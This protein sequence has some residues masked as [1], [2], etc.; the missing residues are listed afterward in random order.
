MV[1]FRKLFDVTLGPADVPQVPATRMLAERGV[2]GVWV[3][4]PGVDTSDM[5]PTLIYLH[6]GPPAVWDFRRWG[7]AGATAPRLP[8]CNVAHKP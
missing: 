7:R 6:G 4:W 1:A 3:S 2:G 5:A 8:S